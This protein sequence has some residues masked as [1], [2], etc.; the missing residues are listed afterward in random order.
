MAG[1]YIAEGYAWQ[2]AV[3][4]GE[5]SAVDAA[6]EAGADYAEHEAAGGA[7]RVKVVTF[8]QRF[9]FRNELGFPM[10]YEQWTPAA[11]G[12][13]LGSNHA[14]TVQSVAKM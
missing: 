1:E 7:D 11:P 3:N 9:W 8:C 4:A 12:G 2:G 6:A 5:A 13:T 10:E 14:Y